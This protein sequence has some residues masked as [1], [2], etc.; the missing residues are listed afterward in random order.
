[1]SSIE[2]KVEEFENVRLKSNSTQDD[3]LTHPALVGSRDV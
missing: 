1:M 3:R 2:R